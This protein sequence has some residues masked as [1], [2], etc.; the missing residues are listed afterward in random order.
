MRAAKQYFTTTN[1]G[2]LV[3]AM[4][5][6]DLHDVASLAYDRV[7]S[8]SYLGRHRSNVGDLNHLRPNEQKFYVELLRRLVVE[9]FVTKVPSS[10]K[11]LYRHA[12]ALSGA[13]P[14]AITRNA[15]TGV[16]FL[17]MFLISAHGYIVQNT[18]GALDLLCTP[19]T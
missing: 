1:N 10:T 19:L 18:G 6:H 17:A 5:D 13:E 7:S 12:H 4:N 8:F 16:H 3:L 14:E 2:S 9:Q 11:D 15:H